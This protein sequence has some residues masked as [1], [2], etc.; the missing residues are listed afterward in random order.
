MAFKRTIFHEVGLF[1]TDF[2]AGQG[3]MGEDTDF[4]KR[5]EKAGKKIYYA[6][7]VVVWHPVDQKRMSLRYLARWYQSAGRYAAR[8]ECEEKTPIK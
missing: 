6:G 1:R 7:T 3:S 2:G 5:C 4:F 8:I